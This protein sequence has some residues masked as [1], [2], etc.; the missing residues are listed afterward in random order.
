MSDV[1]VKPREIFRSIVTVATAPPQVFSGEGLTN[2]AAEDAAARM[3]L[4]AL[5]QCHQV[6]EVSVLQIKSNTIL[7][8]TQKLTTELANFVCCT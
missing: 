8:C 6:N 5:L 1:Q 4:V 7:L 2:N 3:A